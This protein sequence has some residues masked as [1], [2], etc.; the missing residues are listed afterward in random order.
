MSRISPLLPFSTTAPTVQAG[1]QPGQ[2]GAVIQEGTHLAK[3]GGKFAVGIGLTL[4]GAVTTGFFALIKGI[5]PDHWLADKGMIPGVIAGLITLIL[6]LV[7]LWNFNSE[8]KKTEVARQQQAS[9]PKSRFE[10]TNN[11]KDIE[12]TIHNLNKSADPLFGFS[13]GLVDLTDEFVLATAVA[14]KGEARKL[15]GYWTANEFL[16]RVAGDRGGAEIVF[17]NG[18]GQNTELSLEQFRERMSVLVGYIVAS[19]TT[20][21]IVGDLSH[22]IL[23]THLKYDDI[24]EGKS[25]HL[26]LFTNDFAM[27]YQSAR[28]YKLNLENNNAIAMKFSNISNKIAPLKD[29]VIHSGDA[30]ILGSDQHALQ[31]LEEFRD[32]YNDLQVLANSI[33]FVLSNEN[34]TD[35]NKLKQAAIIRSALIAGLELKGNRSDINRKLGE[36]LNGVAG[37]TGQVGLIGDSGKLKQMENLGVRRMQDLKKCSFTTLKFPSNFLLPNADIIELALAA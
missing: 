24:K 18:A 6:G 19:R 37:T 12:D 1:T 28:N 25:K 34:S 11:L 16:D 21:A 29:T 20:P 4:A 9:S 15:Y 7:K 36:I 27:V 30:T 17:V 3:K 22:T 10:I 33:Q 8:E 13:R 23:N 2:I 35:A 5:L 26:K 31:A 14:K 32:S